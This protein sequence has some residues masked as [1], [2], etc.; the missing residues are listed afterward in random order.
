MSEPSFPGGKIISN[1]RFAT[2][3]QPPQ[4]TVRETQQYI[5][6]AG[7]QTKTSVQWP[8]P[9]QHAFDQQKQAST[10]HHLYA[11]S[12]DLISTTVSTATTHATG[13]SAFQPLQ[14]QLFSSSSHHTSHTAAA[15]DL[16]TMSRRALDSQPHGQADAMLKRRLEDGSVGQPQNR[17]GGHTSTMSEA[18]SGKHSSHST[19]VGLYGNHSESRGQ[20][21]ANATHPEQ[22]VRAPQHSHPTEHAGGV[23]LPKTQGK[24]FYPDTSFFDAVAT[25]SSVVGAAGDYTHQHHRTI[26]R[27][28]RSDSFEMMEDG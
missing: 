22:Q 11:S 5:E 18:A 21:H 10:R 2:R 1:R 28:R 3:R 14:S 9:Q 8:H 27:C 26:R 25:S 4:A 7:P 23:V 24:A 12:M 6:P 19:F 15:G 16:L 20:H 13:T 17:G